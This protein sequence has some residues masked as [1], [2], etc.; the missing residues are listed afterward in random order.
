MTSYRHKKGKWY[1]ERAIIRRVDYEHYWI[2]HCHRPRL[3]AATH[4]VGEYV[5]CHECDEKPP[6]EFLTKLK[7]DYVLRKYELEN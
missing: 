6:K 7:I 2:H 5:A 1:F 4:W 3:V